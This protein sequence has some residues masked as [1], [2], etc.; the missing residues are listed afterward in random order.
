MIYLAL[1][2]TKRNKERGSLLN[3]LIGTVPL[4]HA[5]AIL[6]IPV[7]ASLVYSGAIALQPADSTLRI[8]YTLFPPLQALVG[9]VAFI[10]AIVVTIRGGDES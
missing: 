1:W 2:V 6:V 7:T 8:I 10:W 4:R 3:S 5:I 9:G